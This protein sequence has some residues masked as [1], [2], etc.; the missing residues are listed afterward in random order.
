MNIYIFVATK[1]LVCVPSYLT[2]LSGLALG[3]YATYLFCKN[4]AAASMSSGTP[5]LRASPSKYFRADGH[6][7]ATQETQS[8]LVHVKQYHQQRR[9]A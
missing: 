9:Q 8:Q 4:P 1:G 3:T 6:S 7:H 5:C 2:V